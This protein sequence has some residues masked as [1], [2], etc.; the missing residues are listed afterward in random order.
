MKAKKIVK[1]EYWLDGMTSSYEVTKNDYYNS[2]LNGISKFRI[3][4]F[5]DG[6]QIS[7]N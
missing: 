3:V 5:E 6:Q 4:T 2:Y 1:I 7:C